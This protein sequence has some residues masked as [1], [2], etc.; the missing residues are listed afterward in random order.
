MAGADSGSGC[1]GFSIFALGLGLPLWGLLDGSLGAGSPGVG[2]GVGVGA[3]AALLDPP[4]RAPSSIHCNKVRWLAE[5]A[6]KL[7]PP[8]WLS[9]AALRSSTL[10]LGSPTLTSR[11]A[12]W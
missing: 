8:P 10:V 2:V 9:P 1:G 6:G 11:L 3:G 7:G 4:L 5:P 12:F